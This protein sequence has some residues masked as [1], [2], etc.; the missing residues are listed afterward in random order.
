MSRNSL[1]LL[2]LLALVT[3]CC[4]KKEGGTTSPA[5]GIWE[6]ERRRFSDRSRKLRELRW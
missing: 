5:P 1:T 6:M 4:E 2:G 3:L